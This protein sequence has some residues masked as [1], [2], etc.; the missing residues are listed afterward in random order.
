MCFGDIAKPEELRQRVSIDGVGFHLRVR[1][2]LKIL[3]MGKYR[4]DAKGAEQV[5]EPVPAGGRFDDSTLF[6]RRPLAEICSN[7]LRLRAHVAV[8]NRG[9]MLIEGA[10]HDRAAVQIN[11]R[12]EHDVLL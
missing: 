4:V 8:G 12:V 6:L 5:T 2:C 11:A 10:D 7:Q 3:G 1:D 9:T